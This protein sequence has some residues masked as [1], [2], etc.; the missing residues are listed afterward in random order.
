MAQ[1]PQVR[2]QG[3]GSPNGGM[4]IYYFTPIDQQKVVAF[5]KVRALTYK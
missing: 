5:Q 2:N 1:V 3:V 4:T